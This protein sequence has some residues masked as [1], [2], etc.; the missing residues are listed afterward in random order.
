MLWKSGFLVVFL[1]GLA[2]SEPILPSFRIP[3]LDVILQRHHIPTP[4][5]KYTNAFQDFLVKYL[6]E[7]KTEDELV[8]RFTIFSR[9]MD[10][11]ERYNK[12]DLGKVTYELND[13]SDL[14]DEEW[15]KFL[16]SPKPKSP[17]KSAAKPSH[18]KE[19]RFI[20]ESVDWRNVKGNN[21]VTGIKYQGPCGSCWAFAT[22]AAIESAVS[23]SGGGL[24]SLSSQQLLDCTPVSDKCGGGE[25]VEALSY[26]QF[27]GVTSARNY[28]YY[29]WSTTCRENVPTVAK[30]STWAEAENEEELAE[31]VA[32]RG[33]MIVC[34]NFATNK[35]R[36]YHSG[37]AEDPDCGTEPTHALIVIGY[38]P[39]YWILKNTY[40]KVWG[41][42]GY[43]RVKR[44]VNWCGIN[45][46]KPLLPIL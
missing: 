23:I 3:D 6:R 27:H 10:L 35:N 2:V 36:F 38:G 13:F 7:Y 1:V 16:M 25:P 21:H 11:V 22:A 42:K 14:S 28:P 39:D 44:G 33:P 20:P 24:Q 40:S 8:K 34:A 31:M 41:E 32:L 43:M 30:I 4:D 46:E 9:N 37:I 19:K 18:P 17:S 26:A 45:T 5:A 15:K 12:E 29:F